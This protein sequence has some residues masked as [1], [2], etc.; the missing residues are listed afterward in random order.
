MTVIPQ[1][2]GSQK[3]AA[4]IAMMRKIRGRAYY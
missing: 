3:M 4:A 1:P 2:M